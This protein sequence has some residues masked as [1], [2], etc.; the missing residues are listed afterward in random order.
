M[1]TNQR[2]V[3]R[4]RDLCGPIRGQYYLLGPVEEDL[5]L[6]NVFFIERLEDVRNAGQEDRLVNLDR[7]LDSTKKILLCL[8]IL[9]REP[10]HEVGILLDLLFLEHL[11]VE[12]ELAQNDRRLVPNLESKNYKSF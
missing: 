4:S 6:E 7:F 11:V 1:L 5:L 10:K 12:K 3:F 9:M 2:P 8:L